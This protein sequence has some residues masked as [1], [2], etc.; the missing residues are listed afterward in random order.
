MGAAVSAALRHHANELHQAEATSEANAQLNVP[1][2]NPPTSATRL[3]MERD[4]AGETSMANAGAGASGELGNKAAATGKR[5]S[6]I[7][8]LSD[9]AMSLELPVFRK[10]RR[11]EWDDEWED[12]EYASDASS[13]DDGISSEGG[14]AWDY[15]Y[16]WAQAMMERERE[17]ERAEKERA[18]QAATNA[19]FAGT[20]LA[21]AFLN[22]WQQKQRQQQQQRQQQA[23]RAQRDSLQAPPPSRYAHGH[24]HGHG[25]TSYRAT[26]HV[27]PRID[28]S[29]G[30]VFA[31]PNEADTWDQYH[32]SPSLAGDDT[33]IM[34][35]SSAGARE[36]SINEPSV[37]KAASV[38]ATRASTG[39]LWSTYTYPK[40]MAFPD[41]DEDLQAPSGD[42]GFYYDPEPAGNSTSAIA[43]ALTAGNVEQD[44][45]DGP[46]VSS[47]P[48]V[49]TSTHPYAAAA[50]G[51]G[52]SQQSSD[53]WKRRMNVHPLKRMVEMGR[54]RR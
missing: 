9:A 36:P 24:G 22:N 54:F 51:S 19:S 53:G 35:I 16:A 29:E 21:A 28:E 30:M 4:T 26:A 34:I 18:T 41:L 50:G 31:P 43:D 45:A 48:A 8:Q 15:G 20:G 10:G 46:S 13:V 1:S 49:R 37:Y 17:R 11:E 27:P 47:T 44:L 25:T 42:N 39:S 23:L 2:P 33:S 5:A 32:F 7:S 14:A 12:D 6:R 40:P 3:F 52:D 38:A